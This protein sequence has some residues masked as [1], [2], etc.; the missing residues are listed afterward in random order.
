MSHVGYTLKQAT[1]LLLKA[2]TSPHRAW[3][4]FM[5]SALFSVYWRPVTVESF[6][7]TGTLFP[8]AGKLS[9]KIDAMSVLEVDIFRSCAFRRVQMSGE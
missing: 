2:T 5:K 7:K 6:I 1:A 3:Y 9:Y 4:E 8:P